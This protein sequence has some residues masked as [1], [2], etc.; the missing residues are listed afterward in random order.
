MGRV[1]LCVGK[2]AETPY[3]FESICVNVYC[4]EELCYLLSANPFLV[5]VGIMNRE[6][7]EWIDKECGLPNLSHQL[8]LMLNK[9]IQSGIFIDIILDYV[10]YSTPGEREK[11]SEAL[12]GSAG[13]TQYERKKKQGDYLLKNGKYQSAIA[14]Y[15]RILLELPESNISL[16]ASVYHNMGVAYSKLFQ[17]ESAARFLKRAYETDGNESSGIQYLIALRKQFNEGQYI[18]F[19]ADNSQYYE[20]SLKV[21]KLVEDARE[22]FEAT[23]Q[24]RMLSALQIYKEE[25]NTVSYYKEMDKIIAELKE[26]YRECISG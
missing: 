7:A 22:Q 3:R 14:E 26:K 25:G 13:L 1:L 17:F 19:I 15:D 2:Y 8:L 4:M 24:N 9:G 6:L 12:I 10:G 21:E 16:R 23:R 5:D 18:S 20:L 11:I